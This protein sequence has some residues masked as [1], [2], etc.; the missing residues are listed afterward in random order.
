MLIVTGQAPLLDVPNHADD[1]RQLIGLGQVD[2]LADGV[3][4]GKI[5]LGENLIDHDHERG[6]FIVVSGKEPAARQGMPIAFR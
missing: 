1:L 2:P 4:V 3:L 6:V 5:F